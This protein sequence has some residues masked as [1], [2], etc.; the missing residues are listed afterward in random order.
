MSTEIETNVTKATQ[1]EKATQGT[2]AQEEKAK[3]EQ[4]VKKLREAIRLLQELGSDTTALQ[5]D[6]LA[7]QKR[8]GLI[9]ASELMESIMDTLFAIRDGGFV[10][11]RLDGDVPE[12]LD[13]WPTATRIPDVTRPSSAPTT[14]KQRNRDWRKLEQW[15]GE[16]QDHYLVFK[17]QRFTLKN[18]AID[19]LSPSKWVQQ[20]AGWPSANAW[21]AIRIVTPKGTNMS[22]GTFYDVFIETS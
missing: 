13:A 9:K 14:R 18:G 3:L 5:A 21:D 7:K 20:T 19:G 6:L 1:E 2:T 11:I 10:A 4:E 8:I 12:L 22:V 16:H 15:L 17:G